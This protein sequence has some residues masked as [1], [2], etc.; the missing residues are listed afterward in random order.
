M[1][2]VAMNYCVTETPV[3]LQV[4]ETLIVATNYCVTETPV[5]LQVLEMLTV[6]MNYCVTETP[7]HLQV[8]EMLIVAVSVHGDVSHCSIP[9]EKI[10]LLISGSKRL[11]SREMTPFG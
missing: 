1:L 5:H 4:L 8:L 7:V 9:S 6:A 2:I 10:V 11:F 3:H